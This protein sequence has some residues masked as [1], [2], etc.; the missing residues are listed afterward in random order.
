MVYNALAATAAGRLLGLTPEEISKGIA[1]V[2]GVSGRSHI[3]ELADKV[4]L[5][6]TSRCV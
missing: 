5:L 1:A 6:Y 2:E 4:C 3:I